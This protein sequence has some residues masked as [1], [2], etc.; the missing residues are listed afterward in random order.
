MS[1]SLTS[2]DK[3][4]LR[5]KAQTLKAGVHIGKNGLTE[6]I[7]IEIDQALE[8]HQLIKIQFHLERE[9][10]KEASEIIAEQTRSACIGQIG[11]TASFYRPAA[12]TEAE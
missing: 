1:L 6:A 2:A 8:K 10:L 7:F 4:F 5:G 9:A 11:K 12:V 3:K